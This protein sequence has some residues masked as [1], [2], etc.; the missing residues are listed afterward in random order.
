MLIDL[1]VTLN[2][3]TP[4]YPGDLDLQFIQ[5]AKLDVDGYDDNRVNMPLHIGTHMDAPGHMVTGGE[6]ISN[7]SVERFSGNG[8]CID[9]TKGF[10][11]NEIK[12]IL[13]VDII[14]FYTGFGK[15]YFDQKYYKDYPDIPEEIVNCLVKKKIKIIGTDTP[16]PDHPPF[17]MHRILLGNNILIIE[18]L[19][20]K[21]E[22]LCGKKFRV[23][24]F[25][26]KFELNGAPVRVVAEIN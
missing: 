5:T 11:I 20:E 4:V 7:I 16:S 2:K 25:P 24:A 1:S 6:I 26:L 9:A 14:F 18:N 8:I 17:P 3:K 23:Y 21:L 13:E 12:N 15:I 22:Q 10:D 19:S